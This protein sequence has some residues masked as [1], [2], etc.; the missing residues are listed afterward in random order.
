MSPRA[1]LRALASSAAYAWRLMT[2]AAAPLTRGDRRQRD[3]LRLLWFLLLGALGA[4]ALHLAIHTGLRR[5]TTADF[6][7]TNQVVAGR[8]DAEIV[9]SGSSR[10]LTH[11]DST[12]I[13]K[14]TGR[15]TFN[16]G[17]N[18]TQT[19][20]QVAY[21]KT[22]LRKNAK[23]ALVIHNLDPSAF[24]VSH[25]IFD[26]VKLMPYL[27]EPE[28][29]AV[30]LRVYPHAWKWR[31]FPLYGYAVEDL[32]FTWLAGAR[33]FLGSQPPESRVL[34]YQA[35]H[36][37]WT[38]D[39]D[40]FKASHPEGVKLD[41]NPQGVKD[42]AEITEVCRRH[43]VPLLFVY[44]PEY[45]GMQAL[46]S[47]RAELFARFA[48]IS[49]KAGVEIWD[50]S[51]SFICSQRDLFYNSQHLNVTGATMFSQ[52]LARRLAQSRWLSG[53]AT[54]QSP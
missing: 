37:P 11:Y 35:R 32:R 24:A 49:A 42:L 45:D 16:L 28:I 14:T 29:Y 54:K 9:I 3:A 51:S 46:S 41:L 25:E 1:D 21:L 33:T 7:V 36:T 26:P 23:P 38:G 6:G 22:Y 48:E 39:F 2:G 40:K 47:N 34:G 15:K 44:S 53:G 5:V 10:A 50:Y 18:G 13:Q 27:D 31:Y 43:G 17:L 20:V 19:D 52:D 30:V 8:L 12:L 4:V